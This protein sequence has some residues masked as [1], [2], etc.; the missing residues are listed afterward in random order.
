[1]NDI[2]R[3]VFSTN[4]PLGGGNGD[5]VGCLISTIEVLVPNNIGFYYY[6]CDNVLTHIVLHS[7][8]GVTEICAK[9]YPT[10]PSPPSK[11]EI[12]LVGTPC[13]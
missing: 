7:D 6:N 3:G 2:R 12:L 11:Y 4:I 9:G 10:S 1:M 13:G 5:E 8:D